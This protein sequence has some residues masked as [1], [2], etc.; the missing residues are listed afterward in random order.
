MAEMGMSDIA[1]QDRVLLQDLNKQEADA[2]KQEL[3][4]ATNMQHRLLA[5]TYRCC[6][7]ILQSDNP[8]AQ[9]RGDVVVMCTLIKHA[10]AVALA[11]LDSASDACPVSMHLQL[12][13]FQYGML[14]GANHMR[15]SIERV[16]GESS[17]TVLRSP[18]LLLKQLLYPSTRDTQFLSLMSELEA[19]R[20][21][22]TQPRFSTP[23]DGRI[24]DMLVFHPS[25]VRH[26][27]HR[28]SRV[29]SSW[30][31]AV[32]RFTI[33]NEQLEDFHGR[34]FRAGGG[35]MCLNIKVWYDER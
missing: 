25:H 32:L 22:S 1:E 31:L 9:G 15:R 13:G 17:S 5:D 10:T 29:N 7:D 34:F 19:S 11:H 24:V 30:L 6:H 26:Q 16:C 12:L 8:W 33:V 35:D 3:S 14:C 23:I 21:Q 18:G 28:G 4:V 27:Q 20:F 2:F